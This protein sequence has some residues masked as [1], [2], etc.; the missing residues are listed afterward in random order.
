M[1]S[2]GLRSIVDALS[3]RQPE[4]IVNREALGHPRVTA[5]LGKQA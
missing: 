3:G 4:F 1:A 5:W 2:I